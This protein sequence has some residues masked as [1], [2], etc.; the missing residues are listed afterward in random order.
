MTGV[1][2][3]DGG[4]ASVVVGDAP[5]GGGADVVDPDVAHAQITREP[6]MPNTTAMVRGEYLDR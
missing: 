2:V 3:V 6:S 4:G 5:V 1:A